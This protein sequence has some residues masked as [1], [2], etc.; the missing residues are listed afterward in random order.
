MR[1]TDLGRYRDNDNGSLQ[2][3][4]VDFK[5]NAKMKLTP[6]SFVFYEAGDSVDGELR[7][8]LELSF[9]EV[10][11]FH[12][13]LLKTLWGPVVKVSVGLWLTAFFLIWLLGDWFVGMAFNLA[14]FGSAICM[15]L[16]T[17]QGCV[18]VTLKSK[19]E[20]FGESTDT[21]LVPYSVSEV[22]KP[23]LFTRTDF[24]SAALCKFLAYHTY[25]LWENREKLAMGKLEGFQSIS[26]EGY[27]YVPVSK[28]RQILDDVVLC[29]WDRVELVEYYLQYFRLRDMETG[30]SSVFSYKTE[31]RDDFFYVREFVERHT[32]HV[33]FHEAGKGDHCL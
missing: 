8:V 28:S 12:I 1:M 16:A 32:C 17:V 11:R 19:R 10:E 15:Y 26:E 13:E 24:F 30:F 27:R 22:S 29:P 3:T 23:F 18:R 20:L 4:A 14:L 5:N 21:I 6:D 25:D 33:V 2:D 9:A 7:K 31:C